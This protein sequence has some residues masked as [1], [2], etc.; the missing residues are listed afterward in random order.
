MLYIILP[1]SEVTQEML[2]KSRH[3]FGA[4]VADLRT[5]YAMPL[6]GTVYVIIEPKEP[7][8]DCFMKYR[9]YTREEI[10]EVVSLNPDIWP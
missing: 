4:T 9:I 5:S 7:V 1:K 8:A 3:G 2:N 6:I 10:Q